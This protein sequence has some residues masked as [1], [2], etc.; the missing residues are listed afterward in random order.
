MDLPVDGAGL[1][2]LRGITAKAEVTRDGILKEIAASSTLS[3]LRNC[4]FSGESRQFVDALYELGYAVAI[5][6]EEVRTNK[7]FSRVSSE[8]NQRCLQTSLQSHAG[9]ATSSPK[10]DRSIRL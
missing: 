2:A 9:V 10:N 6:A 3:T 5:T 1:R 8:T 4:L 7:E